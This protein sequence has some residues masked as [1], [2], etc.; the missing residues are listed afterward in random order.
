MD[1]T[2]I[3]IVR[4]AVLYYYNENPDA[5]YEAA[6]DTDWGALHY[7]YQKEKLADYRLGFVHWFNR[8][9]AERQALWIA[10]AIE[11]YGTDVK[12]ETGLRAAWD[13]ARAQA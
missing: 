9:D 6:S 2:P 1:L 3:E 10:A 11:K 4:C 5:Q 12:C 8:F 7:D 13:A